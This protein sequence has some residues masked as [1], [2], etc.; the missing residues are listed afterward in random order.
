VLAGR[1][2]R[3]YTFAAMIGAGAPALPDMVKSS[4]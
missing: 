4:P 1:P 3:L 2:K